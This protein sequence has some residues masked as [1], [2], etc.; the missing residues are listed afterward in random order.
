MFVIAVSLVQNVP[1]YHFKITKHKHKHHN[2]FFTV[3]THF[4]S[5]ACSSISGDSNGSPEVHCL[6]QLLVV[7]WFPL[8]GIHQFPLKPSEKS[9]LSQFE[10]STHEPLAGVGSFTRN[11]TFSQDKL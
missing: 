6:V 5:P 2:R 3:Q 10:Q 4:S 8:V 9:T 11:V 1:A 7:T